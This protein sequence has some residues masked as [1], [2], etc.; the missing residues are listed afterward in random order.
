MPS[1][2]LL[3]SKTFCMM[4]WVHTH[5]WPDGRAFPCCMS[6]DQKPMGNV[7]EG[8]LKKVWNDQA[9][10][11]LRLNMLAGKESAECKRCYE[12]EKT[13]DV[14]TLR[15][16]ANT[17]FAK[18]FDLVE[19]TAPDGSLPKVTMKYMDIRWSNLC[20]FKCRSCGPSLSSS[21]YDDHVTQWGDPGHPRVLTVNDTPMFW[22]EIVPLLDEVEEVYFAGGEALFTE[23]HYKILEHWINT[24]RTNLRIRYTTNFSVMS[25]KH[26]DLFEMWRKFS[27]IRVAASLDDMGAR[28]EYARSGTKWNIIEKNRE[29]M[30][31]ELP[32]IYFEITPTISALNVWSFIDFHRAWVEK[33]YIHPNNVRVNL[34]THPDYL[35]V[36]MLP[37]E[38]KQEISDRYVAHSNWLC[39]NFPKHEI[40]TILEGISSILNFV[41]DRHRPELAGSFLKHMEDLDKVRNESLFDVYP[42]LSILKK[43]KKLRNE[44]LTGKTFCVYPWMNLNSTPDG[45]VKLC[46]NITRDV[47]VQKDGG[48]DARLGKETLAEVWNSQYMQDVRTKMLAGE[49]V[50]DCDICYR[51]EEYSENSARTDANRRYLDGADMLIEKIGQTTAAGEISGLP[52]SLE[53]RLGNICNLKCNSCSGWSSS[54]VSKERLHMLER[55]EKGELQ[56]PPPW[57]LASLQEERD[58]VGVNFSW[59]EEAVFENDI[60]LAAPTLQ[61]LYLTG[62][63]PTM[64][65]A[66]QKLV[67]ALVHAN[68]EDCNFSFTTNLMLW[69]EELYSKLSQLKNAEVQVSL[70]GFG[71][72]NDY[73]RYGSTWS[74]M[75]K[76]FSRL[77]TL[78]SNV[79]IV[80]YTVLQSTNILEI[81]K[82]LRFLGFHSLERDIIWYP[83]RLD[84]PVPLNVGLLPQNFREE[85][86]SRLE[87]IEGALNR[88]PRLR[89]KHGLEEAIRFFKQGFSYHQTRYH[90]YKLEGV[91]DHLLLV[92]YLN[93]LDSARGTD[94]RKTFPGIEKCL[95]TI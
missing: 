8:G 40:T 90:G 77:T 50:S 87:K 57:L 39:E 4:P 10:R 13:A 70:D 78:P 46:C 9:Y 28:A 30:L 64:I 7:K 34:L 11:D 26:Y 61:R 75:E 68:N 43:N 2:D 52:T 19:Q 84:Y 49:K 92:E 5:V 21:W 69:N 93:F 48:G 38:L 18:D 45:R 82:I 60:K 31:K 73:I 35:R 16:S 79:R 88:Y 56:A 17:N 42:E 81:E 83:I 41:M 15:H 23:E 37:L 27:D 33:G 55:V 80:V 6:D 1:K 20:N 36:Q 22:N 89:Y 91:N 29:R 32:H 74:T 51:Q 54:S 76:N 85:V 62:G 59:H 67:D 94:W 71:A 47:V 3:K 14:Y 12:L 86:C 44:L 72:A 58:S 24:G 66:N 65:R 63:E 25:Y 95:S 53:L